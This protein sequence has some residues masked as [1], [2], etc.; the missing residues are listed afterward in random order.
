MMFMC[1]CLCA[2]VCTAYGGQKRAI[3]SLGANVIDCFADTG[4]L[5]IELRSSTRMVSATKSYLSSKQNLKPNKTKHFFKVTHFQ[6][7][8]V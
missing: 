3:V 4:V 7:T 6:H 2:C 1:L 5:E 8:V